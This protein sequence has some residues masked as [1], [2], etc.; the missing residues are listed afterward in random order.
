MAYRI[1]HAETE[2]EKQKE[3]SFTGIGLTSRKNLCIH[4]EVLHQSRV[5][6]W[7]FTPQRSRR[8]RRARLWMLGVAISP[9][10]RIARKDEKNRALSIC[11]TGMKCELFHRPATPLSRARV[12]SEQPR[13]GKPCTSRNMDT[14]R[15]PRLW[16]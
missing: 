11:A 2:A 13:A 16:S 10:P 15:R 8:R 4:P 1:E 5:S 9:M 3:Q 12:E 6:H 7:M 14:C